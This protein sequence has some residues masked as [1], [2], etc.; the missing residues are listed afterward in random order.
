MIVLRWW[1]GDSIGVLLMVPVLLLRTWRIERVRP[2]RILEALAL[3]GAVVAIGQ[4]V[5]VGWHYESLSIY[6]KGYTMYLGLFII[7]LRFGIHGICLFLLLI[8]GQSLW[9][10]IHG[11][12]GFSEKHWL[13]PW[14]RLPFQSSGPG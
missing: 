2:A 7:T 12:T 13:P 9:G 1:M 11:A 5:F 14:A 10:V 4:V 3:F 8:F 6:L